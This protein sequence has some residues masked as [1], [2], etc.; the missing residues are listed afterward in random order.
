MINVSDAFKQKLQDG[1]KVWQEVEI[2]FLDGTVKTAK[3]KLWVK[4]APFL[5]ALKVAVFQLV[6]SYPSP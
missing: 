3:M 5:I 4:T 6:V 1:K 2:T